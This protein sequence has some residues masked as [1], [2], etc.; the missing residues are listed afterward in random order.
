MIY[1]LQAYL[2]LFEHELVS[3]NCIQVF[4]FAITTTLLKLDC[5]T[6]GDIHSFVICNSGTLK[7]VLLKIN[8]MYL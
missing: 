8:I 4:E 6:D 2:L 7:P 1:G 3:N 5:A